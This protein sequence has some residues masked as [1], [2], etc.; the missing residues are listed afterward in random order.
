MKKFFYVFIAL[1]FA[2]AACQPSRT[3]NAE[4]QQQ[5]VEATCCSAEKRDAE[6]CEKSKKKDS[7]KKDKDCKDKKDKK[8]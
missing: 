5:A 3:G 1:A 2:L 4:G 6:K 8:D 7:E